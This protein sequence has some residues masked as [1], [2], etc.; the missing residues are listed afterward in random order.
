[1][2]E[3]QPTER[4]SYGDAKGAC[5]NIFSYGFLED[6]MSTAKVMFLDLD[7]PDDDPLRPAKIYVSTAA[8]GFRIFEKE[9]TISWESDYIWLI[10]INEEDGLDFKVRQTTDGK[11]EVQAFWKKRELDT[12][13]LRDYLEA[14]PAW[15][16]FQLRATVLLQDRVET[17]I[18]TLLEADG[19]KRE[20]T[21]RDMPWKLAERL[22]SLELDMLKR[23]AST[24]DS[25]V[26]FVNFLAYPAF[27]TERLLHNTSGGNMSEASRGLVPLRATSAIT[28]VV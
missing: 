13:K 10:V 25:Q 14:D 28:I 6:A 9:D 16:V 26:R 20:A 15:D 12:I 5:E 11:R 7:I 2:F 27:Q 19:I 23:A 4:L 3:D 17:Q 22:R 24:F 21:V 18:E 8:P 1:L